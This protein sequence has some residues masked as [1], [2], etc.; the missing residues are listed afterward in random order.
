MGGPSCLPRSCHSPQP[1][2]PPIGDNGAPAEE[3]APA[4]LAQTIN[5]V[6]YNASIGK[7]DHMAVLFIDDMVYPAQHS[8]DSSGKPPHLDVVIQASVLRILIQ[9]GENLFPGLRLNELA[10]LQIESLRRGASELPAKIRKIAR[11]TQLPAHHCVYSEPAAAEKL[12]ARYVAGPEIAQ[13]LPQVPPWKWLAGSQQLGCLAI[14]P[15]AVLLDPTRSVRQQLVELVG[16][17]RSSIGLT[18]RSQLH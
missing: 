10:W 17:V 13:I 6:K 16:V 8:V 1:D 14:V 5:S 3:A 15:H 4:A 18:P 9:S 12:P 7:V 11:G 2:L